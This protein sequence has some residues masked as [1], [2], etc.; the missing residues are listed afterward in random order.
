MGRGDEL[1]GLEEAGNGEGSENR[2][3]NQLDDD[4]NPRSRFHVATAATA[5]VAQ[6]NRHLTSLYPVPCTV[7]V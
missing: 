5:A 7:E 2:T 1:D 4:E 3:T 6:R